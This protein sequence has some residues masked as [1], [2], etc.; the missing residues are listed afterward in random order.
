[1]DDFCNGNMIDLDIDEIQT[2]F[3][4]NSLYG[5]ISANLPGGASENKA[6]SAMLKTQNNKIESSGNVNL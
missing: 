4:G 1:M 2:V 6:G 5:A 3:G